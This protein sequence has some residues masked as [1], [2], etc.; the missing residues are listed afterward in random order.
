MKKLA[1]LGIDHGH[2][3]AIISAAQQRRDLAV[4]AVAQETP[5]YADQVAAELGVP[6]YR[7]YG[8]CLDRERPEIVGLAM[9]NG[10]RARWVAEALRRSLP[11]IAD[12]PL[13]T[14]LAE[15]REIKKTRQATRSPLCMMLTCRNTG[16]YAAIKK[17]VDQKMIG[18][19]LHVEGMR[20]YGLNRPARPA[21]MFDSKMYG[22]PAVDILIHDYD[23][24][25]WLTGC[26]WEKIT[27]K[28]L[29]SGQFADQ[30]FSDL[31]YLAAE[32][33]GQYI[34]LQ[35][36][37]HAGTRHFH[38][39]A[40]HGATGTIELRSGENVPILIKHD[41]ATQPLEIP[42][43]QPLAAQFFRA[44]LDQDTAFPISSEDSIAVMEN[45]LG[46]TDG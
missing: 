11:V 42:E 24:A 39:F 12:K 44:L 22:G 13:C 6:C 32:E 27:I 20:Y 40:V 43:V 28:E 16:S 19:I 17:A 2:Y 45:L 29:R 18:E 5:P 38:H 8:E 46:G 37:W 30:D 21:W 7:S 23:L 14:T 1:I 35:M 10:G 3:Q 4:C 34:N 26:A 15:I 33:K 31:A 9:Y 36:T 25:R 41:G